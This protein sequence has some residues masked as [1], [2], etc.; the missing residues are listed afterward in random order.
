MCKFVNLCKFGFGID[1]L[2]F[3]KPC[4]RKIVSALPRSCSSA[5]ASSQKPCSRKVESEKK[6]VYAKGSLDE[7]GWK[8]EDGKIG[9]IHEIW[10]EGKGVVVLQVFHQGCQERQK[11]EE[12]GAEGGGGGMFITTLFISGKTYHWGPPRMTLMYPKS[13]V[14]NRLGA[15]TIDWGH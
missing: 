15:S 6:E 3:T 2:F 5:T 12:G 14:D 13:I 10:K 1:F 8:M 9:R 11:W 7:L 4:S